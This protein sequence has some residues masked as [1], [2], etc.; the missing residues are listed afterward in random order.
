MVN[1]VQLAWRTGRRRE[2][3][4]KEK[5]EEENEKTLKG[6][7]GTTPRDDAYACTNNLE[8]SSYNK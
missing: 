7:K 4:W 1:E 5:G 8:S 3:E 2:R 6:I